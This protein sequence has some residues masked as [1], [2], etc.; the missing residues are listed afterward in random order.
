ML[1]MSKLL[2]LMAVALSSAAQAAD[3]C[4]DDKKIYKVCSPQ[5]TLFDRASAKAKDK[6][7]LLLVVLGADWCPWCVSLHRLLDVEE[8]RAK[9]PELRLVEIGLYKER[10]RLASGDKVLER[11]MKSAGVK[12]RPEGVPLLVV[13]NPENGK[14]VFIDTEPLE[15][16]TEVSKGHDPGKLIEA[17]RK[18][19]AEVR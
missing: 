13:H 9:F 12:E 5:D 3:K 4:Y 7:K 1:P 17:I 2:I 14:T 6:K 10:E 16:N 11:L 15:K 19:E 8:F 18:A